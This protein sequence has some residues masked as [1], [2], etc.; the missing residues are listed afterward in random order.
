[1]QGRIEIPRRIIGTASVPRLF[2]GDHGYLAKLDSLMTIDEMV[3]SMRGLL[4]TIPVGLA[5]GDPRVV[6]AALCALQGRAP[7]DVMIHADVRVTLRGER[8]RY[9]HVAATMTTQLALRGIDMSADPVLNFLYEVGREGSD[10][11]P[12]ASRLQ[13]ESQNAESFIADIKRAAPTVVSIGGD[14]LDLLLVLDRLDL[15]LTGVAELANVATASG[16]AVLLTT[17]VGAIVESSVI[18]ALLSMVDGLL[19]PLNRVGFG[20]LPTLAEHREWIA[21]VGMPVIGMHALSGTTTVDEALTLLDDPS[22]AAL[23]IG[24]SSKPHQAA[25]ASAARSYFDRS[26]S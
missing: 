23:V 17:Y 2:L 10:L 13:L 9:R 14:W 5:A 11:A 7:Q 8:I 16:S 12:V 6:D 1:M 18:E 20:T 3:E 24:A 4:S 26:R 21:S 19:V 25:L 22:V 15:A